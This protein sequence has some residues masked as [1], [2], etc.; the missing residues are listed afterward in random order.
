MSTD[1][2]SD[3]ETSLADL[4]VGVTRVTTASFEDAID[5]VVERPAVGAPLGIEGVSLGDVGVPTSPTPRQLQAAE[6]GV[7]RARKGIAEYGTLVLQSDAAGTEPVSLYPPLHVAVLP[8]S[9]VICDVAAG[10]AWLAD[11]F[12][13]GR[14][15]AVFE[16]GPSAT[17]DMG[18][19]VLGAHG[20]RRVHVIVV[21]D[22]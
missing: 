20:P 14:D 16:T 9:D 12:E 4:D 7:T 2:V 3:F 19:L 21:T 11:E 1:I 13:A 22:R 8:E 15:S 6:T 10:L 17:A 18:S 5:Q